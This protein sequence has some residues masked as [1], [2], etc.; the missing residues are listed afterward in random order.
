[1]ADA[2]GI[3]YRPTIG[4]LVG[5]FEHVFFFFA[6]GNFMIPTDFHILVG[7][8]VAIFYFPYWE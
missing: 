4:Y 7:G 3:S 8:L 5:A 6:D 2:W 1:M